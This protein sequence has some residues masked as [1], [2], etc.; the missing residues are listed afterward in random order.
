M[1]LITVTDWLIK[2]LESVTKVFWKNI[3]TSHKLYTGELRK[4]HTLYEE[5]LFFLS[6]K[7]YD[8]TN[9]ENQV[10][11]KTHETLITFIGL[12]EIHHN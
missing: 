1:L 6:H 12:T 9:T 10:Y 7:R 2:S 5:N 11:D 3:E 4:S 8:T